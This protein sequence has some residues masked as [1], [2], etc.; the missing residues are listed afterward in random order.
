M[1][2]RA[3]DEPIYG[4]ELPGSVILKLFYN[5][6]Y[7][8][9]PQFVD[10]SWSHISHVLYATK[11][12]SAVERATSLVQALC[13][14]ALWSRCSWDKC[15]DFSLEVCRL[16]RDTLDFMCHPRDRTPECVGNGIF[17]TVYSATVYSAFWQ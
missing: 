8:F 7:R 3:N 14:D 12:S 15:S 1:I 6:M 11:S 2:G 17:A 4:L 9:K 13:T 5:T 16:I 10:F